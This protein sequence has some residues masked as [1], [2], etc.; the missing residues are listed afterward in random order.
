MFNILSK[1]N[2]LPPSKVPINW[3]FYETKVPN[4]FNENLK[5]FKQRYLALEVPL[6]N[7]DKLF[8]EIREQTS[9]VL[10]CI[11]FR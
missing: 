11:H 8:E 10:V 4:T 9:L 6:P 2:S 3:G 7:A 5:D 1:V